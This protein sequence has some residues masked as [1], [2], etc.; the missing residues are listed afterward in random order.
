MKNASGSVV[1]SGTL[2][3]KES[4]WGLNFWPIDFSSVVAAGTYTAEVTLGTL[5]LKSSAF[6]IGDTPLLD[7]NIYQIAVNQLEERYPVPRSN[8]ASVI[9][10]GYLLPPGTG[11]SDVSSANKSGYPSAESSNVAKIWGDAAGNYAE[12]TAVGITVNALIDL[13]KKKQ[14]QV[15]VD[16]VGI[17]ADKRESRRKISRVAARIPSRR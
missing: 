7:R 5:T 12:L 16:A 2:G 9:Q 6:T 1:A 13:Y 4:K 3:Q 15:H 14:L 10:G 11:G 17:N 8:L